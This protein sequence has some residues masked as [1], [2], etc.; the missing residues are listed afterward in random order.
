[1]RL[2]GT[3]TP[4]TRGA[5]MNVTIDRLVLRGMDPAARSAFVDG[6]R[7]ELT[8]VLADPA[9]RAEMKASRRTPVLRLGQ[10]PLGHGPSNARSLGR[11]VAR[12]IARNGNAAASKGGRL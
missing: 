1:M 2:E 4:V 6:L 5:R 9:A 11:S 7:G 10:M 12:A 3:T 8:R